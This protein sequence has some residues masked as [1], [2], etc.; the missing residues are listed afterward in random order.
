[1]VFKKGNQL[2]KANKG[3]IAWNKGIPHSQTTRDNI[4]KSLVGKNIGSDNHMFGKHHSQKTKE[5]LSQVKQGCGV[6][7][8]GKTNIYLDET[9]QQMSESAI[10]RVKENGMCVSI[11]KYEKH[12]LDILEEYFNY[13]ILRQHQV[14]RYFLDGYCPAL[15]LAIEV[16]EPRHRQYGDDD[17]T[18]ENHIKQEL[19]C[20]FLRIDVP[21]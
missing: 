20:Q 9:K 5:H 13:T 19:N 15:N 7:N 10:K 2:G 1:M 6:W 18:R 3:N 8:A 11:G 21:N 14:G 12:T 4:K 16:D 17:S